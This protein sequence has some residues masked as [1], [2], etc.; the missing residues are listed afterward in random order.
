MAQPYERTVAELMIEAAG[1]LDYPT[2]RTG[3]VEWFAEHYPQVKTSTVRAH[4]V[5]LTSNDRNRHHYRGLLARDP[6][7]SAKTMARSSVRR[8]RRGGERRP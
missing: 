6:L 5:G 2:T 4:I 3:V 1:A 7:F 8:S